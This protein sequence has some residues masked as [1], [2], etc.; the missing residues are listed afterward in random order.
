MNIKLKRKAN[1]SK[2]TILLL[3]D[4]IRD[5]SG[6]ATQSKEI[7]FNTVSAFNWVQLAQRPKHQEHGKRLDVS[8][9]VQDETG[10]SDASVVLYPHDGYGN[11]ASLMHI[12]DKEKPDA[13]IHFTDPRF[14]GWLYDIEYKIRQRI[15][16]IYYNIWDNLPDPKWNKPFYLSCDLLM[17]IS[18]QTYGINHR[19]VASSKDHVVSD[20]SDKN[21]RAEKD[22][23][24]VYLS[25]VPHGINQNTFY[26]ILKNTEDYKI[27]KKMYFELFGTTQYDFILFWSNRNIKR[28]R[29]SDVILA[30]KEFV[31]KVHKQQDK[32]KVML[33]LHTDALDSYGTNLYE[34]VKQLAPDVNIKFTPRKYSQRELNCL[35]NIV[36][37]TL[38]ISSAEGFGLTTAESLMCGTPTIVN[39]TGGLQD[40]CGFTHKGKYLTEKDYIKLK[41]LS[42]TANTNIEVEHG[43]WS[44][45]VFSTLH[46]NVGS[47]PTPYIWEDYVNISDVAN[48]IYVMYGLHPNTRNSMGMSGRTYMI[49]NGFSATDLG[50]SIIEGVKH[51]I[52]TFQPK[53]RVFLIEV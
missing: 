15:P 14:W 25:Y 21:V 6:V 18:K 17:S 49:E 35:Y 19:I 5:F 30:Y 9:S 7:I 31:K 10:V 32:K 26:P 33:L 39:V 8:K 53:E 12:V 44:I 23:R 37:C 50:K 48:A 46:T 16:I 11:E 2:P 47:L 13:I 20:I 22:K 29:P 24:N 28:K 36:D 4:D 43:K 27:M 45:P 1:K 52:K 34:V 41:T 42:G 3:S 40:Q 38:N 51:T